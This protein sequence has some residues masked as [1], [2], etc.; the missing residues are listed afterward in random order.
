MPLDEINDAPEDE[1]EMPN[2]EDFEPEPAPEP[3]PEPVKEP[4]PIPEPK[5]EIKGIQQ[6]EVL[7]A[8]LKRAMA[9]AQKNSAPPPQTKDAAPKKNTA[10]MTLI[11]RKAAKTITADNGTVIIDVGE[12]ITDDI[13]QKARAANKFIELSMNSVA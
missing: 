5:M 11:G 3:I 9:N 13:I 10:K 12:E 6:A 7:K 4:E 2:L 1:V 8:A